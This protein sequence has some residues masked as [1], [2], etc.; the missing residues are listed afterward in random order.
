[1]LLLFILAPPRQLEGTDLP[2]DGETPQTACEAR[3]GN[4]G[5]AGL[6]HVMLQMAPMPSF[7]ARIIEDQMVQRTAYTSANLFCVDPPVLPHRTHTQRV[8]GGSEEKS[9][10]C[11]GITTT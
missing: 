4:V 1:M 5:E 11:D 8:I 6:G 9:T 3:E 7:K 2:G 10:A